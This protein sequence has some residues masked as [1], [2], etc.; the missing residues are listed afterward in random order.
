MI[1]ALYVAS[2]GVYFGLPGVDPWDVERDARKYAG[3]HPVVAHPPCERWGRYWS[4]GPSATVR[5]K[6]GDDGG[7]FLWAL[8]SV[9][10]WRE[11][12]PGGSEACMDPRH[13]ICDVQVGD[14]IPAVPLG[15]P[16]ISGPP[17]GR[18]GRFLRARE[19]WNV[20]ALRNRRFEGVTAEDD[21]FTPGEATEMSEDL[22]ITAPLT[23][24]ELRHAEEDEHGTA[25]LMV[26]RLAQEVRRL[27]VRLTT[28]RDV[29]GTLFEDDHVPGEMCPTYLAAKG[30]W[31]A[32]LDAKHAKLVEVADKLRDERERWEASRQA[33][34]VAYD[35]WDREGGNVDQILAV[36]RGII[37]R[38]SVTPT[39]DR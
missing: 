33:L 26:R 3:P 17:R 9:R 20:P 34:L 14:Q 4:G 18:R 19:A 22:R 31:E 27:R 39:E 36:A 11:I 7:C 23:E 21:P 15:L 8:R 38:S 6:M 10:R 13:R 25:T 24:G 37:S 1:A 16:D 30:E 12:R 2:A 29:I 5:R 32:E 28:A 35:R